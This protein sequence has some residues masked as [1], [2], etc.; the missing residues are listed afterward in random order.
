MKSYKIIMFLHFFG[1]VYIIFKT[2][3]IC[4]L[5]SVVDFFFFFFTFKAL[6]LSPPGKL[7]FNFFHEANE[8]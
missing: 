5:A 4:G 6:L 1:D 3:C 7:C 2:S 8:K